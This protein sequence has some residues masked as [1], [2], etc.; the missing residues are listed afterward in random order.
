[1]NR[2][3]SVNSHYQNKEGNA[4]R[5]RKKQEMLYENGTIAEKLND[6]TSRKEQGGQGTISWRQIVR[7]K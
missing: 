6:I 1:M 3:N 4:R 7:G 2:V 5:K